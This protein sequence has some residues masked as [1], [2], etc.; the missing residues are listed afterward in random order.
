MITPTFQ[1]QDPNINGYIYG[2]QSCTAYAGAMAASFDRQ[3]RLLCTGAQVRRNSSEPRPDPK[4]PG[5]NL[6][7]LDASL[8]DGWKVNL[9]VIYNVAWSKVD[10]AID[11]GKGVLLQGWY[12]PIADSQYDAGNGF[13]GNHA[14][15]IPPGWG[16][17]D[18]LASGKGSL[19][20][21]AGAPYPK[22]LLREFAGRLNVGGG[23]Y[24]G[25]GLGL[26]YAAFTRDRVA[27][28]VFRVGPAKLGV[29]SIGKNGVISSVRVATTGGFNATCT[30]PRLY[31]WPGHTS[32]RLVRLTNGSHEGWYVRAEHASQ[33]GT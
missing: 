13:R 24:R 3:V 32:Q 8:N 23:T 29:F 18:P 6:A 10:A 1:P 9:D 28:W 7:Q 4:S 25:I 14:M 33:V 27:A 30:P 15:F 17:M 31:P 19:Y 21:Y 2:W 22:A 12:A 20:Q 26:A 11:A 5:L 16:A